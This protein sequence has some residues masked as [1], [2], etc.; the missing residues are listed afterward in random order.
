MDQ[1]REVVAYV[2]YTVSPGKHSVRVQ[3]PGCLSLTTETNATPQKAGLVEGILPPETPWLNGTPAGSPNGFVA[4]AG[5]SINTLHFNSFGNAF[6]S[7]ATTQPAVSSAHVGVEAAGPSVS[8]GMQKRW[9]DLL[10]DARWIM[11]STTGGTD[12]VMY[13]GPRPIVSQASEAASFHE[14]D[15]GVRMGPR[16][17][18]WFASLAFGPGTSLGAFT[19]SPSDGSKGV[20]RVLFG[21]S[22]WGAIDVQPLCDFGLQV[23]GAA[24]LVLDGFGGSS[25]SSPGSPATAQAPSSYNNDPGAS[26][27]T[28]FFVQVAYEPNRLCERDRAGLFRL[29]GTR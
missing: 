22:F 17:P 1:G 9:F 26:Y 20:T 18:I 21:G 29:E 10:V 23:G 16:F 19:I 15:I 27:S 14:G 4:S 5:I 12:G 11:G 28:T 3:Y 25:S 2:P 8:L 6:A 7:N 24:S 13:G